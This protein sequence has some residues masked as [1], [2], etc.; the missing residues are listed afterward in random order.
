MKPIIGI[1]VEC[2]HEPED[3]RSRGKL[4]L[5]WN[6]AER[7]AVAGGV[8]LLVPPQ[9][10]RDAIAALIDGWLIPGGFD[11]DSRHFGQEMHPRAELQDPA[12]FDSEM[13]LYRALP[14]EAP[15]LGICYGCQFLNVA[16]GGDLVQH[17]PDLVGHERH[18]GG[19]PGDYPLEP[20]SKLAAAA[21]AERMLGLSYHHQA[22]SRP[23]EGLRVV[24]RDADGVIEA[25]EAVDRPWLIGVQ[26]HPERTPDDPATQRLFAAFIE[27]AASYRAHRLSE[28]VAS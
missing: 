22:C 3:G 21:G 23:G 18:A 12:R 10:D 2:R 25:L 6:Y 9:A 15:V 24:A 11:I 5:N 14:P 26:W 4:E 20:G 17:L 7:V 19:N 13:A 8:P 1:T 28:T 16:R 27:A